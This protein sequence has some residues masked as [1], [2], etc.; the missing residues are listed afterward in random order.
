MKKSLLV[1]V[2]GIQVAS[3]FVLLA[4]LLV[5]LDRG[6]GGSP[7]PWLV[8]L[9]GAAASVLLFVVAEIVRRRAL[10]GLK[11]SPLNCIV[12]FVGALAVLYVSSG[13]VFVLLVFGVWW[14]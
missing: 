3:S 4:L 12:A 5:I 13:I 6:A 2:R 8:T 1:L 9:G 14:L 7:V 10:P 11:M